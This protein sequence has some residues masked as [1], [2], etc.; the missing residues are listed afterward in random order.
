MNTM[1]TYKIGDHPNKADVIDKH[2]DINV[3]MGDWYEFTID[4][5]KERLAE[6][7]F[8]NSD[9]LF[10]GFWSPGDGA[11]FTS[12]SVP[13]PHTDPGV[14][15]AWN[16]LL[17][18]AAL[19]GETITEDPEDLAY[20][21]VKRF[22]GSHYYH[23]NTVD[24]DWNWSD[25]PYE[26]Y[27]SPEGMQPFVD[28]LVAVVESY[29]NNLE[30]TVTDLCRQIYRDLEKEYEYLTSDEAV[31]ETLDANEYQLDEDGDIV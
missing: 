3:D 24:L 25:P 23:E 11:S 21:S 29:F 20:G 2:R 7:G 5:W 22:R 6:M 31:E 18:A 10:S 1:T 12:D 15:L 27:T 26:N 28:A 9:I 30:D 14:M 17:G 13:G 8:E 19:I 16:Q 4:D